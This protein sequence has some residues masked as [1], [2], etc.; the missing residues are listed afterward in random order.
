MTP[1]LQS[2]YERRLSMM[3]DPA[4]KDLMEGGAGCV[5]QCH[6]GSVFFA[7]PLG[8]EYGGRREPYGR[9]DP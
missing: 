9:A 2:Y 6:R 3:G 5:G 1:E 8:R 7:R 4:W